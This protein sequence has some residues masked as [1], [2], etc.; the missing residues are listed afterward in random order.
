MFEKLKFVIRI[1]Q[2]ILVSSQI[3]DVVAKSK[4]KHTC[5][6]TV[7][8]AQMYARLQY[9]YPTLLFREIPNCANR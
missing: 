9:F 8:P 7:V 3:H 2:R 1:G 5:A 6:L 4:I